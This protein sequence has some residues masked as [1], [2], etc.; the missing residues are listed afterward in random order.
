[1][2]SLHNRCD[3]C[4]IAME[5]LHNLC[6]KDAASLRNHFAIAAKLLRNCY[7]IAAKLLRNCCIIATQSLHHHCESAMQSPRN[8]RAIATRS[9]R[10]RYTIA[11]QSQSSFVAIAEIVAELFRSR[12]VQV[13]LQTLLCSCLRRGC[14]LV[15]SDPTGTDR[16]PLPS[17]KSLL[18]VS[19]CRRFARNHQLRASCSR[20]VDACLTSR[21][22]D[23]APCCAIC[24]RVFPR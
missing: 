24:T 15:D 11:A 21:I 23:S 17:A 10:N 13:E 20:L 6:A 1:M 18:L 4:A 12:S 16:R 8:R 19:I 14:L 2:K 3:R 5:S 7:E 22:G 9:M